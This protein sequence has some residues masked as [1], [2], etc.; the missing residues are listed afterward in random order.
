M[1]EERRV[2]RTMDKLIKLWPIAAVIVAGATGYIKMQIA[3]SALQN[4]PAEIKVLETRVTILETQSAL[5]E[6]YRARR[7]DR[8]R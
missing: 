2:E 7:E 3:L 5:M 8:S 1:G 6:R 4:C